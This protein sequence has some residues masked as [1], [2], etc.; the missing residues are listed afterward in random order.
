MRTVPIT[1]SGWPGSSKGR[2]W[3]WRRV[4]GVAVMVGEQALFAQNTAW[5]SAAAPASSQSCVAWRTM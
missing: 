4:D 5:R 3:A 1:S 2:R